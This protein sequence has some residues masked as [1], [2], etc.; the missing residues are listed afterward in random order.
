MKKKEIL[1]L[2]TLLI[3]VSILVAIIYYRVTIRDL[4][5]ITGI[6]F[7]AAVCIL[8]FFLFETSIKILNRSEETRNNLRL[9][10][11]M[12]SIL[13]IGVEIFLR[14]G[15]NKY[16]TY[17]E[18]TGSRNYQS[19]FQVETPSWFHVHDKNQEIGWVTPEFTHV[20]KTNSLGLSEGEV[21]LEKEPNEYRIVALGDSFTEGIGVSYDSTWVK[22]FEKEL[23]ERFPNKKITVIN[24]GISGSDVF[25]EYVLLR[26]KLLPYNLDLVVVA[27]N[28]T[29]ISEDII[30]RGGME[31]FQADGTTM[32]SRKGP[33]W[34]W[35]Y[36]ISYIFR[37]IIHDLF[38]YNFLFIRESVMESEERKAVENIRSVINEFKRI[39]MKNGFDLLVV[40][41]PV[42]SEANEGKYLFSSDKLILDLK[43]DRGINVIDLLD[44]YKANHVM[45]KEN[46]SDF[47]GV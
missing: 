40:F 44:Y 37:H 4:N 38:Q 15:L 22:V 18:N 26:E 23:R 21:A 33:S 30:I 41:H 11:I 17:F 8:A 13:L 28:I 46:A 5:F 7:L 45:T 35:V 1:L 14:F 3:L 36:A 31:R 32:F 10:L 12:T 6:L 42:D 9:M 20:R 27:I 19:I 39:S 2:L 24:A 47:F 29:D 43:N 34:E 16:S 25:F